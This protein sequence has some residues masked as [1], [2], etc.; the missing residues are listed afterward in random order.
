MTSDMDEHC[1]NFGNILGIILFHKPFIKKYVEFDQEIKKPTNVLRHV[2]I[3]CL[4][5][6]I[7][8]RH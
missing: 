7:K 2:K 5:F 3:L 8:R 1:K 4:Y 6:E